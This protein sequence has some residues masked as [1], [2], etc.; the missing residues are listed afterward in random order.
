[1]LTIKVSINLSVSKLQVYIYNSAFWSEREIT[2]VT[3]LVAR[4]M[5]IWTVRLAQ[6]AKT[7]DLGLEGYQL[8]LECALKQ[9]SRLAVILLPPFWYPPF[10]GKLFS[11]YDFPK[12]LRDFKLTSLLSGWA[13]LYFLRELSITWIIWF[14]G[15]NF[16][17]FDMF[18]SSLLNNTIKI[19][20]RG[21]LWRVIWDDQNDKAVELAKLIFKLTA[22]PPLM[23]SPTWIM[24]KY[25]L[26][27]LPLL[28][29]CK[30]INP[31]GLPWADL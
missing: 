9:D 3:N 1:M 28:A 14:K 4:M 23:S 25:Y 5:Q 22:T 30:T 26:N 13:L 27:T 20:W 16:K 10:Q 12:D 11:D 8:E 24:L 18:E 6:K 29:F 17:F 19:K 31:L 15:I 2:I 7:S 21:E